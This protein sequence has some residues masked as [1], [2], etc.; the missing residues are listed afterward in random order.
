MTTHPTHTTP[1]DDYSSAQSDADELVRR[2]GL[3]PRLAAL[4]YAGRVA[5]GFDDPADIASTA[6]LPGPDDVLSIDTRLSADVLLTYGGP[7]VLVRFHYTAG[8]A[9]SVPEFWYAEYI[10]TD[11]PTHDCAVVRLSDDDAETIA[12]AYVGGTDELAYSIAG[13]HY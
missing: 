8:S 6:E 13:R 11:T 7:T 2:A 10:T 5:G 12:A 9:G 3:V 1:A 4:A